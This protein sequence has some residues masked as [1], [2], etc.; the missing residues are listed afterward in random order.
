[1]S[2]PP[3]AAAA[4]R[5][6]VVGASGFVGGT[7]VRSLAARGAILTSLRAPRFPPVAP[8]EVEHA[9]AAADDVVAAVADQLRGHDVVVN[10][11][12]RSEAG[13]GDVDGLLAA[14]AVLPGVVARA[15]RHARVPR[16]VHISSGA[17]QGGTRELDSSGRVRP[18]SAYS[19]SKAIGEQA[20]LRHHPGTVV[21]R[22]AGVQGADRPVS[23][24]L[25]QLAGSRLAM[26]AGA[27]QGNSPQALA[28]NVADAAAFLALTEQVP[29]AIVHH[30]SEGVSVGELLELLGGRPPR[31]L[32]AW[33]G[34]GVVIVLHAAG[35][36]VPSL[37]ARRRRLEVMW[38]GQAQAPS[39]LNEAGW[40]PV[41]GTEGWW[42]LGE[43]LR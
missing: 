17:V 21:Y 23:R 9:L 38:F 20:A 12:G 39:W 4:P 3:P 11:A 13:S 10:A 6:A 34:R 30:P 31:R 26:V 43:A 22:P 42:I 32:P 1:M 2:P 37:A 33:L 18:F 28:E 40:T 29:P 7:V 5:A 14:N 15:A 8:G 36:V 41:A 16:F 25:V 27:G 35:H 24:K 19:Y